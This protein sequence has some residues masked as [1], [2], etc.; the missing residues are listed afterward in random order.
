MATRN[1]SDNTIR[2]DS[3]Q[4][5]FSVKDYDS[6]LDLT[7]IP[8]VLEPSKKEG[9]MRIFSEYLNRYTEVE[10]SKKLFN[11]CY[12]ENSVKI[13]NHIAPQFPARVYNGLEDLAETIMNPA[14]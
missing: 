3:Q 2:L 12:G 8:D 5:I 6:M 13:D 7:N 4:V 9:F 10:P 11:S 14:N 1:V